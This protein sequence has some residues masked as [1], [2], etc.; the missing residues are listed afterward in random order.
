MAI[1]DVLPLKAARRC[2]IANA[3]WLLGPRP[4]DISDLLSMVAFTFAMWCHLIRLA[5]GPFIVLAKFG[6]VA[7]A[8]LHVQRLTAKQNTEITEGARKLRTYFY[9][10]F[11]KFW[12]SVGNLSYLPTSLPVVYFTFRHSLSLE[13]DKKPNKCKSFLSPNFF[14]ERRSQLF[15]DRLLARL[16]VH[17][18]AKFG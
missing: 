14:R 9:P 1:N 10:K 2:V 3:K 12:D 16:T 5:S 11:I 6:W 13:V 18:L 8:D 7:L 15:C 17:R 4:Q